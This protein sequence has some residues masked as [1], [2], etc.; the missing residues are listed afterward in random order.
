MKTVF[1]LQLTIE[2]NTK[3]IN[4][5]INYSVWQMKFDIDKISYYKDFMAS[6][7]K[8]CEVR[9]RVV[10]TVYLITRKNQHFVTNLRFAD[11]SIQ[12]FTVLLTS[13]ELME[14]QQTATI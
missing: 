6:L 10:A 12:L 8:A 7:F 5:Q 13:L 2:T 14:F 4:H 3:F 1:E 11:A 9:V